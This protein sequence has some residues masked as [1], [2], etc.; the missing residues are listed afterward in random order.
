MVISYQLSTSSPSSKL[1]RHN[2]KLIFLRFHAKKLQLAILR[3]RLVRRLDNVGH[4]KAII[5]DAIHHL[6]D[7]TL[8]DDA[9]P[10]DDQ[11]TDHILEG[12]INI[13]QYLV[14]LDLYQG[15]NI[16]NRHRNTLKKD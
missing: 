11:Y 14:N 10:V 2:D 15:N 13:L 7:G 5:L 1:T 8:D 9:L 16:S 6:V 4:A 12:A 3:H